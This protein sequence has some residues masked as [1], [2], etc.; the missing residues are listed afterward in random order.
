VRQDHAEAAK[1]YRLAAEHG[2]ALA[3]LNLGNLYETGQGVSTNA[4]EAVQWYRKAAAQGLGDA[5]YALGTCYADGEGV[6]QD[7]VEAYKWTTLAA[8]HGNKNAEVFKAAL[9][10]KLNA[11][12]IAKAKQL[13]DT[14]L[15][16]PANP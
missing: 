3:Q 7:V 16:R 1:W 5:E 10:K 15:T 4:A 14:A 8:A 11:D 12:Q 6:P 2:H 13:A 9:S